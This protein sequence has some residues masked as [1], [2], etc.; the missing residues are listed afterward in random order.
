MRWFDKMTN[1]M[2]KS[3][4]TAVKDEVKSTALDLLPTVIGVGGMI[5]GVLM[6]KDR[7]S[8]GNI[9]GMQLPKYSTITINNYYFPDENF[10]KEFLNNGRREERNGASRKEERCD[11]G[12]RKRR[13]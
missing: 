11:Q 3:A 6:L 10:G 8:G 2:A 13:R 5:L 4:S 9:G 12:S 1:K 7:N